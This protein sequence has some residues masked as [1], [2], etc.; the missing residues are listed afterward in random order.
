MQT[1]GDLKIALMHDELIRRGGAEIVFEEM[2]R[3]WPQADIYSLYAGRPQITIEGKTR[4]ITT[5]FLQRFPL[6]FRRHPSRL[7]PFLLHGAEQL[8]FSGY[9]LVISSASAF[10]K[11]IVTRSNIPHICYCH[12]PTRYL[13][14]DTHALLDRLS[15]LAR[16]PTRILLHYLRLID[17]AAAQ[18]VDHFIANSVYTQ[19]RIQHYYRRSSTV[20]Y[21]PVDTSFFTPGKK[22]ESIPHDQKPFLI[23]GRLTPSKKTEQA[24]AVCQKL[25]LPLVVV[26]QG[27]ELQKLQRKSNSLVTFVGKVSNQ[28]LRHFYRTS[29]ALIQTSTE[30]FGMASVEALAC[31]TPVIAFNAGGVKEIVTSPTLGVLYDQPHAESLAEAMR[32]FIEREHTFD[33]ATLQ[34]HAMRFSTQRFREEL[35][36]FVNKVVF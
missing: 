21:P 10:A 36:E 35:T 7:L 11:A 2:A 22:S 27:P 17:F 14:E 5:S 8:D 3:I 1:K 30:D 15:F 32:Q 33:P 20:I 29:R 9:Q 34:N 28:E 13:W 26:G 16:I 18:R 23:V 4:L 19:E 31:G 24:I 6:W 12:T 25:R